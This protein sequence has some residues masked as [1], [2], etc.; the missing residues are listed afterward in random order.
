MSIGAG[1]AHVLNLCVAPQW[2]RH[3]IGA[4]LLTHLQ[5]VARNHRVERMLL[6]VRPSNLAAVALYIGAGFVRIGERKGYYPAADGR[7]DALVLALDLAFAGANETDVSAPS[8][9]RLGD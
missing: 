2:H 4:R 3:G 1:E 8:T 5:V 7:E 9:A 6:E